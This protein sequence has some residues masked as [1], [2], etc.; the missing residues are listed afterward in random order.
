MS[1]KSKGMR[2]RAARELRQSRDGGSVKSKSDNLKRSAA[3]KDLAK[4]EEWLDGETKKQK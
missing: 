4:N 1:E 3:F 2:D